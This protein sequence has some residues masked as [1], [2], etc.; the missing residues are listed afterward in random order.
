MNRFTILILFSIY[1]FAH[2]SIESNG[3][4]RYKYNC[5]HKDGECA[6]QKVSVD[7]ELCAS[8]VCVYKCCPTDEIV[9]NTECLPGKARNFS[10]V[11]V[12]DYYLYKVK[13]KF[14]EIF[15]VIT[16]K[17]ANREFAEI[18]YFASYI[19]GDVY[20]EEVSLYYLF[21]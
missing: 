8:K 14:N 21:F 6:K 12:Y 11:D 5:T 1:Q 16:N 13:K 3:I 18:A 19:G 15:H 2:S 9:L 20:L 10:D 17:F 7:F 4:N